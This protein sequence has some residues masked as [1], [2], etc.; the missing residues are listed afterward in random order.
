MFRKT[1]RNAR[2]YEFTWS[3]N[4]FILNRWSFPVLFLLV[5]AASSLFADDQTL[6][7]FDTEIVPMLT[8]AGCNS[9][10]CHGAAAGRGEFYLSLYGS[11]PDFDHT[12]IAHRFEG[13]RVNLSK[14]E[15][16][17]LLLKST[18][19]IEHGGGTRF[20]LDS[21]EVKLI[22]TWIAQGA[23]R[24]Q[25]RILKSFEAQP[26]KQ[27]L[28]KVRSKIPLSAI[29]EF[30]DQSSRDVTH[31]T[32]FTAEDS[33]AVEIDSVTRAAKVLR[34]GQHVV[35][36]RFL[37]VVV[38]I[39]LI[40]SAD[41]EQLDL[42]N[43]QREN[44]IDEQIYQLLEVL[45][46]PPSPPAG[47]A[48]FLRRIHLDLTGRLPNSAQI[49]SYQNDK[50]QEKRKRFINSLLESEEF[51]DY[52]TYEFS[53][54]LRIRSQPQDS[55]G[56]KTY[57]AW[58][59]RE[60]ANGT[61]FA[62]IAKTLLTA[63]GDSHEVGPANFFRTVGGPREQAEFVSELFMGSRLR[64]ANCHDH[65]LDRWS[66]DDY[67]GLAAIF[68][69]VKSGREI[70]YITGAEVVHPATGEAAIPRIP[71]EQFLESL[72]DGR[73]DFANWLTSDQNK[74]FAKAIVNR[75]WKR[76][77]GRGLVEPVDDLRT[78]NPATHPVLLQLLADD[79][80]KHDFNL[81]HTIQRIVSSAAYARSSQTLPQNQTDLQYYSHAIGKPFEPEVLADAIADATGIPVRFGAASQD[82]RAIQLFDS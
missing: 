58:L 40:L 15:S 46:I 77:M 37:D 7:D 18:E 57:H 62:A 61:S 49:V 27:V 36:A 75:I 42:T 29:A 44:F 30:S 51:N 59:R 76:L 55:V 71:G 52:W 3:L 12:S 35:I 66:Q 4:S 14:P 69:G 39:V 47:E 32:V 20:D 6:I 70:S 48:E 54:L 19:T 72:S 56:A 41:S 26:Q 28:N 8:K 63:T 45:R 1:V 2:D 43:L 25:L 73:D 11:R 67:H 13:R 24:H 79:F 53:K 82:L 74:Y 5:T 16:S 80:V 34:P 38:P 10:A 17:L 9:G 21:H 22:S 65:P 31:L 33:S 68:A 81:R 23:Q 60:L 64:C 78:T 50:S